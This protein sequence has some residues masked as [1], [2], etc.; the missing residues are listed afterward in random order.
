[1]IAVAIVLLLVVGWVIA[2]HSSPNVAD[3]ISRQVQS[4]AAQVDMARVTKFAWDEMFVFGPYYP[5]DAICRTLNLS[6]SH[7]SEAGVKDVD[8]GEFL[9][10]FMQGVAVSQTVRVPRNA[11]NFDESNRCLAKPI[12]RSA[13]VFTLKRKPAVYLVC[14]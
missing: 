3:D 1:M 7:C 6:A 11:A 2:A 9:L 12:R 13:A 10:V 14:R 4:G 5:K 8:E